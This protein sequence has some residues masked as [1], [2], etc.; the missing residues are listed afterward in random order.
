MCVP[1]ATAFCPAGCTGCLKGNDSVV[2]T[3]CDSSRV[4]VGGVCIPKKNCKTYNL[5]TSICTEC[6]NGFYLSENRK[7]T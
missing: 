6:E 2:C 5:N 7:P 4:L 1:D 3:S